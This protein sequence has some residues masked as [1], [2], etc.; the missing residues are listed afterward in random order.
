MCKVYCT[1]SHLRLG[2]FAHGPC[3]RVELSVAFLGTL[4]VFDCRQHSQRNFHGIRIARSTHCVIEPS[5]VFFIVAETFGTYP[6][7]QLH[8]LSVHSRPRW[9]LGS[10]LTHRP[11]H[12]SVQCNAH[13]YVC[14]FMAI[15]PNMVLCSVCP[16]LGHASVPPPQ[17]LVGIPNLNE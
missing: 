9:L 13:E 5:F 8:R 6:K 3:L 15:P 14:E 12:F 11:E 17:V 4:L 16:E 1:N 7:V 10:I 2:A